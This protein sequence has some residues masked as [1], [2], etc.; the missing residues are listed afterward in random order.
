[1]EKS[2]VPA[3]FGENGGDESRRAR[4]RSVPGP[5]NELVQMQLIRVKERRHGTGRRARVR[6]V[7]TQRVGLPKVMCNTYGK[8]LVWALI[9]A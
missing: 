3:A 1:M 9:S 5:H 7:K 4:R 8:R 2:V 6:R